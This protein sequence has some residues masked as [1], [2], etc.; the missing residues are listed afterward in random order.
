MTAGTENS[1]FP[2][3]AIAELTLLLS[4]FTGV[5]DWQMDYRGEGM[6][7]LGASFAA[8]SEEQHKVLPES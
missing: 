7:W 3:G 5:T 4:H 1:T 2:H 8:V 6:G